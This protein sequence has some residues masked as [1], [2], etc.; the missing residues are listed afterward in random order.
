MKPNYVWVVEMLPQHGK[1]Y[2]PCAEAQITKSQAIYFMQT[3]ERKNPNDK[4]R[5]RKYVAEEPKK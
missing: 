2:L 4:F 5:F 1:R 3:W